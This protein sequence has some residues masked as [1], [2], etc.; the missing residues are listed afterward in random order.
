MVVLFCFFVLGWSVCVC[1]IVFDVE[2]DI[3]M[4]SML[5]S[6]R[7]YSMAIE[8]IQIQTK[9]HVLCSADTT[10]CTCSIENFQHSHYNEL[11]IHEHNCLRS[12]NNNNIKLF[13][14][15]IPN[16]LVKISHVGKGKRQK[17]RKSYSFKSTRPLQFNKSV[18]FPYR[19]YV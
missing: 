16:N 13:L 2:I 19:K 11:M 5:R 18:V 15:P 8:K 4:V 1:A 10:N 17:I 6:N 3:W 12:K 9:Y 14:L 7:K